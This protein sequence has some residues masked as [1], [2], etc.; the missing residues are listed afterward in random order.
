MLSKLFKSVPL[1]LWIILGVLVFLA[2]FN[3]LVKILVLLVILKIA[4]M[5]Y[6]EYKLQKK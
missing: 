1:V 6:K 5:F 2:V 3:T 4:H